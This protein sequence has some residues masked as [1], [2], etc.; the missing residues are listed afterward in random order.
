MVSNLDWNNKGEIL[1][2]TADNA[3]S[4]LQVGSNGHVLTADSDQATGVKWAVAT[5]VG[6]V[7]YMA[8]SSADTA[9]GGSVTISAVAFHAPEGY[10]ICNGGTIPTSGTFQGVNATLLQNLRNFLGATYGGAGI[11]PNLINNFIEEI[12]INLNRR[13]PE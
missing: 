13:I 10:L 3:A 6:S 1:V 12:T 9:T 8:A 2:A 7:F 4:R 5:P 11:L